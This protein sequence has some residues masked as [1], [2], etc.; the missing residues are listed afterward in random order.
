MMTGWGSGGWGNS[1]WGLGA[2]V[3]A[4]EPPQIVP[5]D[6]RREQTGVP[7]TKPLYIRLSDNV[8]I[9]I[10]TLQLSVNGV[11]WVI[12][13]V[14]VNGAVLDY[15]VNS[16]NGYDIIVSPPTP[17]TFGTKQEVSVFVVDSQGLST[18]LVYHFNVGVGPRLIGI[19]NPQPNLLLAHFNQPMMLDGAFSTVSNWPITAVS[20]GA[21]PIEVVAVS[22][23]TSQPNVAHIR[24]TGGGS[25]YKLTVLDSIL[26]Q[27]GDPLED[28]YNS[29]VF[30]LV[31]GEEE[32]P[33]IRLFDSI[34]GPLGISQR[35]ITRR[36][37]D[38]H[39]ADRSLALALDEQFRL[40]FQQLDNSAGR[41]GR[42]GKLRTV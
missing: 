18:E 32:T 12:G 29:V 26:S 33:T 1:Q 11:N 22:T 31:Y 37:M 21:L 14:A 28:G 13:G 19:R 30:D 20:E 16:E 38:Q 3:A 36:S 35:L 17:Y 2:G 10:S 34:F 9:Q 4:S 5:I 15:S 8:G 41:D 39:T 27:A 23:T 6:P 7:Q 40:K 24:Y 25:E 42:P